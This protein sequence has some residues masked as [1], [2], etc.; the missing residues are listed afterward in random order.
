MNLFF[1]KIILRSLS[2]RGV[3]QIINILGLSIGLAVVL[4]I[5]LLIF[6]EKSFD[7]SFKESKNIYRINSYLTSR[8]AGETS[9]TTANKVGP[10][11]KSAI[12]EMFATVRLFSKNYVARI[13]EEP[14]RINIMWADEDFFRL[15]E[16]PFL[17]GTPEAVMSRPNAIALSEETA[18]HLFGATNP[19]GET[20]SLDNNH[21]VEVVAVFKDYP[22]NTSFAGCKMIA[23]FMHSYPASLHE[24]LN[25]SDINYETFCL[26]PAKADMASINAKMWKV[27]SEDAAETLSFR[28]M[29]QRLEDIHLYS[30]KYLNGHTS[31]RS[32]IGK[33]RLLSLMAIVI[34]IVACVNYMNLSTARAQK[35]SKEIGISKT[36]GAKR[37][38]LITRLLSETGIYTFVS[39]IVAFVLAFMALPIFNNLLVEQLN[40]ELAFKP[41]FLGI[42]LLIWL[43]TTLFS[44]SYPVMYLSG[45][46]PLKAIRQSVFSGKSSN[47]TVRKILSVGQFVVSIVLIALALIIHLQTK[48]MY[49]KD[50]G[51]NPHNIIGIRPPSSQESVI[52]A[53]ANDY[54]MESSVEKVARESGFFLQGNGYSLFRDVDDKTGKRLVTMRVDPDF[55]DL[56]Q[57]KLIAGRHLNE[58]QPCDSITQIILNRVAVDYLQMTPE[59]IIGTRVMTNIGEKITEV[60]GVVE[61][62]N[63]DPLNAPIFGLCWHNGHSSTNSMIVLRVKNGNLTEQLTTYKQ[64]F[65]KHFPNDI[66]E[67]SFLESE[68]GKTYEGIKRINLVFLI[69]SVL[70]ILV[71]CMGVFGLT[72]FMAEQRTKE[73]GIRKIMG[74]SLMD[75]IFLFINNYTKL[76]LISLVIAIPVAWWVGYQTLQSFAYRIS[77]AWWILTVAALITIVLTLL[78]VCIQAVKSAMANPV[79]SIKTE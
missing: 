66:F 1:F 52:S 33:L 78:T 22:I 29:L 18:N 16:T 41:L 74:A 60:C 39:L 55:I 31:S 48:F 47:A 21:L 36:I 56:M 30:A 61:N 40:F 43:A 64:I 20:F 17:Y 53:L 19:M 51:F 45:L 28:P 23:P 25:W 63:F 26:L 13:K 12:P 44:A 6:N 49:N 2:K 3:F 72:A 65:K 62:F 77:I 59:E 27:S 69:F 38:E 11:M 10:A 71:A 70:A 35:R 32:D 15:F 24:Q 57:V 34:L 37:H 67:P 5:S 76:L 9:A 79:E 73:I 58:K 46:P 8:L 50:L 75:I 14:V 4:L 54:R 7:R 68:I 42:A